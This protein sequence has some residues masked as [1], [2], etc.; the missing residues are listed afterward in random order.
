MVC[1]GFLSTILLGIWTRC[2]Y[3]LLDLPHIDSTH[4]MYL[5]LRQ[6]SHMSD[7]V[8]VFNQMPEHG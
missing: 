3:N 5:F 1:L 8:H 6:L 4:P 2:L 7:L